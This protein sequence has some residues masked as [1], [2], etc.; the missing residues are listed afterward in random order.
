M[1][2][3]NTW[4]WGDEQGN[5]LR[6]G[7]HRYVKAVYLDAWDSQATADDPYILAVTGDLARVSFSGKV[8][9]MCGTKQSD[10][11]LVS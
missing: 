2:D 6:E 5:T 4:C 3:N 8:V 7:V 9:T 1:P 11:R 10:R